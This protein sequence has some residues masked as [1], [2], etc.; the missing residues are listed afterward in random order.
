MYTVPQEHIV[1]FIENHF[2]DIK[3]FPASMEA[4]VRVP[5]TDNDGSNHMSINF[6]NGAWRVFG[7][8][9]LKGNIFNLYARVT[10]CTYKEAVMKFALLSFDQIDLNTQSLKDSHSA[11]KSSTIPSSWEEITWDEEHIEHYALLY[12]KGI[13]FTDPSKSY[14][15]QRYFLS[16]DP[17]LHNRL[18]MPIII[19]DKVIFWTARALGD[20][21]NAKYLHS[22][23]EEYTKASN[24]VYPFDPNAGYVLVCEGPF[25]AIALQT[26]GINATCVFG[27]HV[28]NTQLDL[29]RRTGVRIIGAFDNDRAGEQALKSLDKSIKDLCYEPL[30]CVN[31]PKEYKDWSEFIAKHPEDTKKVPSFIEK[32]TCVYDFYYKINKALDY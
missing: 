11:K 31:P 9:T 13:F 14:Y 6:S 30:H 21:S 24:V 10:G 16:T 5:F 17:L 23:S 19:D 26:V 8:D 18:I 4:K 22:P 12:T 15:Q 2:E 7:S 27:A 25:D 3:W 1:E 28:S 20:T 29:I 32:N